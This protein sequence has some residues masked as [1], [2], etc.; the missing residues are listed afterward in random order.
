MRICAYSGCLRTVCAHNMKQELSPC[1]QGNFRYFQTIF[2]SY[3][4]PDVEPDQFLTRDISSIPST[5]LSKTLGA[6]EI[7]LFSI[8]S[9]IHKGPSLVWHIYRKPN[10]ETFLML[11][12]LVFF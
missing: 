2:L 12:L 7:C 3:F 4:R 9:D 1:V 6:A 11:I 8:T 10:K 5:R